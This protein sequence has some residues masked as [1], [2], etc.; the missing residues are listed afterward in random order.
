MA[1]SVEPWMWIIH[2][3]HAFFKLRANCSSQGFSEIYFALPF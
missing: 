1:A 2:E 3:T